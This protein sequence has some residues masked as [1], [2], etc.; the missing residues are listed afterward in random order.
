[1]FYESYVQPLLSE[2]SRLGIDPS[3]LCSMIMART[4]T[5][6]HLPTQNDHQKGD[7]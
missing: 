2:A 5:P 3:E 6:D 4:G 1:M 7:T